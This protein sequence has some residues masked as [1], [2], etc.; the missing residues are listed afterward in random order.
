MLLCRYNYMVCVHAIHTH[1]HTPL[2]CV[3]IL[4]CVV[5]LWHVSDH[6]PRHVMTRKCGRLPQHGDVT[7]RDFQSAH[8]ALQ[9]RGLPASAGAQKTITATQSH[10]VFQVKLQ[11]SLLDS[12]SGSMSARSV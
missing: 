9:Q 1:S 8:D 10:R 12:T 3:T 7:P 2:R 4:R 6:L 11:A 5:Y